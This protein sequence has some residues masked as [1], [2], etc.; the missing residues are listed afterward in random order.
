MDSVWSFLLEFFKVLVNGIVGIFYV[1]E[2]AGNQGGILGG[3]F[4]MFNFGKYTSLFDEWSKTNPTFG[5][6]IIAIIAIILVVAVL[7]GLIILLVFY[8]KRFVSR[9]FSKETNE[10]LIG[11]I[12]RLRAELKKSEREKE[13]LLHLR[14]QGKDNMVVT[15]DL[16]EPGNGNGNGNGTPKKQEEDTGESRFYKLVEID[17]K[18][19]NYV[20]PEF[21]YE[22]TLKEICDHFRNYAC[23]ELKL[24]YEPRIIRLFFSAFAT[25][26]V[27]ILQGISGTGKTS[28]PLAVGKWLGNP[29]TVASVQ[30]SWRDRTEIFGYFNEFTKRFNETEMLRA[31]YEARHTD[32]VFLTIVDEANIARVEYYFAELLSILEMPDHENWMIDI[33]PSGWDSDPELIEAGRFRLPENMWYVCTINNDDSTFA[34]SDKVYDRAIPININTKGIPFEVEN[35]ELYKGNIKIDY[36]YLEKLFKEAQETYKVSEENLKKLDAMDLYVIEHFQI[37]FGNRI[38]KQ[39]KEFI[40]VYVACGGSELDG[41]DYVLCNKIL[42]KLES[43]NIAYI[44]DEIDGYIE[45]L[46]KHFGVENMT[47]SKTYL[48]RLKKIY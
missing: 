18:Y 34:V 8:V 11:E 9:V 6:W 14:L 4:E 15:D 37:A 46:D 39:L 48:R 7:L 20:A 45:Y 23:S 24:F 42:R 13:R 21:N 35:P 36:H 43:L 38:V 41:L 17:K 31:M 2:N 33:A 26:R 47:E 12:A 16:G 22:I 5:D 1:G 10:D 27:I 40:P 3:L 30:P 25:T 32:E 29:S 28:L 44:R 19:E